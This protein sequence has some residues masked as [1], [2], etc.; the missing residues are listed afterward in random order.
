MIG[1]NFPSKKGDQ[2][3]Q[4]EKDEYYALSIWKDFKF[5]FENTFYFLKNV[6]TI[7]IEKL[8]NVN[9]TVMQ[10]TWVY[11]GKLSNS[12]GIIQ[13]GIMQT[14]PPW[15]SDEILSR[16]RLETMNSNTATILIS[17]SRAENTTLQLP[18]WN[19]ELLFFSC[20]KQT[21]RQV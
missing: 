19:S 8:Y 1:T 6:F 15:T 10:C 16:V 18:E 4:H 2:Y 9:Q 3:L 14:S 7:T 21:N 5:C 12:V 11:E 20:I 13:N 17:E